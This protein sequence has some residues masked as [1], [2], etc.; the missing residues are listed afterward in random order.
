MSSVP[1]VQENLKNKDNKSLLF[2]KATDGILLFG[3]QRAYLKNK[4][5]EKENYICSFFVFFVFCPRKCLFVDAT[6]KSLMR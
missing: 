1:G 6:Q 4:K 3:Q 5:R 2:S